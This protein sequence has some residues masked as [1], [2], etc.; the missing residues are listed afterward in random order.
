MTVCIGAISNP[1]VIVA[2]DRMITSGDIQFEQQQPKIFTVARNTL[3]LISG[4]IA[5]QTALVDTT[6]GRS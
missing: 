6:Q 1:L 5:V 4:D 3:A 2:T